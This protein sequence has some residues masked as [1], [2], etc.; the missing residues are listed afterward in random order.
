MKNIN[1]TNIKE[2]QLA[3]LNMERERPKFLHHNEVKLANEKTASSQASVFVGTVLDSGIKVVVKSY[4]QDQCMK[5]FLRELKIFILLEKHGH[6]LGQIETSLKNLQ[7]QMRIH[8]GL[9]KLLSFKITKNRGEILMEHCGY[10]L[11]VW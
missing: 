6:Y 10:E 4:S 9:P 5:S 2:F 1:I 7:R 11:A 8:D 3:I